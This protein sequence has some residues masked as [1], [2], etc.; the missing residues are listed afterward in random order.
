MIVSCWWCV[1][2]SIIIIDFHA[3]TR[4]TSVTR[5]WA[6][7]QLVPVKWALS[8]NWYLWRIFTYQTFCDQ[9]LIV[10]SVWHKCS[11]CTRIPISPLISNIWYENPHPL[12][13]RYP[14]FRTLVDGQYY[15]IDT[16]NH[17]PIPS[18]KP[19]MKPILFRELL[20]NKI[21]DR[22]LIGNRFLQWK[23]IV[24]INLTGWCKKH[25]AKHPSPI[26]DELKCDY[27][28]IFDQLMP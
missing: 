24:E 4:F 3:W 23:S 20:F 15:N 17:R 14:I 16:K 6:L 22:K 2:L 18:F 25:L 10:Y 12:Q 27:A 7:L 21:I 8:Y 19:W 9:Y 5:K 26:I 28:Q 11:I 13:S 1:K